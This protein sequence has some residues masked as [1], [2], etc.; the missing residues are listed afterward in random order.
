MSLTADE[1]RDLRDLLIA[2]LPTSQDEWTRHEDNFNLDT[3]A[4][5]EQFLNE[6]TTCTQRM[7]KLLR[8]LAGGLARGWLR[9]VLRRMSKEMAKEKDY[10]TSNV[11]CY[12]HTKS[13][14]ERT[15]QLSY[16]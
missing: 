8:D 15:I 11:A 3:L 2:V 1:K 10:W 6:A 12:N 16:I 5:T 9:R 7:Q 14:F 4:Q 13:R